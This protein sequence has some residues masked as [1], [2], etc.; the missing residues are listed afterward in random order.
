MTPY[1]ALTHVINFLR[2]DKPKLTRS[3]QVMRVLIVCWFFAFAGSF[4]V[5]FAKGGNT[6]RS[7]LILAAA[8]AATCC[9]GWLLYKKFET[10]SALLLLSCTWL[11]TTV[12]LLTRGGVRLPVVVFYALIVFATIFL[13]NKRVG[14]WVTALTF[15]TIL[16]I[17]WAEFNELLP[18]FVLEDSTSRHLWVNLIFLLLTTTVTYLIASDVESTFN[19]AQASTTK[20]QER[21]QQLEVRTQ[22][23]EAVNGDLAISERRYR[24]FFDD[25]PV[26]MHSIDQQGILLDVNQYWLTTLGY[27]KDEVLRRRSSE[28][29]T[30]ESQRY[31]V[32]VALPKFFENGF[33]KDIPYQMVK[34]NGEIIDVLL[35]A[36]ELRDN[37]GN[38]LHS[39]AS[40]VDVTAQKRIESELRESE[41]RFRTL[42][43]SAADCFLLLNKEGELIGVNDYT[44]QTIGYDREELLGM[45]LAQFD[46]E[47]TPERVKEMGERLEPGV[48]GTVSSTLVHKNG[49]H[50]PVE[51]RVVVT[52]INNEP[53]FLGLARDVTEQREAQIA[54]QASEYRFRSVI[55]NQSQ[56]FIGLLDTAGRLLEA[57]RSALDFGGFV[58]DDVIGQ[59]FWDAPWWSYDSAIQEQLMSAIQLAAEG[60]SIQY[61]VEV[62]GANEQ[63][64]TISFSL[65]PIRNEDGEIFSLLAEGQDITEMYR[66]RLELAKSVTEKEVLLKEIH[67]RVK[68]NLQVVS[69]ILRLQE[70]KTSDETI[71][72]ALNESQSRIRSIELIHEQFYQSDNLARVN[73]ANYCRTLAAESARLYQ[74]SSTQVD[75]QLALTDLELDIDSATTCGLI[76]NEMI[77]NSLK[78]AF[79]HKSS[80]TIW[81]ELHALNESQ[82]YL[83]FSDDG[84]G[85][86]AHIP[87]PNP[88]SLG[89]RLIELLAAQ[90]HA[91]IKLI[92]EPNTKFELVF[93]NDRSSTT[94]LD[95][96][97]E[98]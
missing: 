28:F 43:N 17:A 52:T 13:I 85:I 20:L 33:I 64:I 97:N 78:Y 42:V 98:Q 11:V 65:N 82:S 25:T 19:L 90:M 83:A 49:T 66:S 53:V 81:V 2:Y 38:F 69:S 96:P 21:R 89:F 54:L 59:N 84:I 95:V 22:Q 77:S 50:V 55:F 94:T 24:H 14:L 5:S 3:T 16:A 57:N 72:A 4:I 36:S 48:P 73:F 47:W 70:G 74:N 30:P 6:F 86:P 56:Q 41:N 88:N 71:L 61:E 80:G 23:L 62:M 92:R 7:S 35:S 12:L 10:A 76:L 27:E 39:L 93:D 40:I 9:C 68:N 79:P 26:M 75:F 15:L 63:L 67:H 46:A 58:A 37:D 60:E 87:F 8:M 51:I 1:T 32:E 45:P 31:A 44:C 29:L 91:Q 34:K 18:E